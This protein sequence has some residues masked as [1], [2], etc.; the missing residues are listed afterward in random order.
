MMN[1]LDLSRAIRPFVTL[2]ASASQMAEDT[3]GQSQSEFWQAFLAYYG[4]IN[5][6]AAHNPALAA[7][8]KELVEF[9]RAFRRKKAQEE[10]KK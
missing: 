4:A 1:D 6:A 2:L 3:L 7:E 8:A 10:P 5:N 9:M